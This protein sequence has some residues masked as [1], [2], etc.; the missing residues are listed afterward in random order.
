[1]IRA[2][3]RARL[4]ALYPSAEVRTFHGTGHVTAL[5]APEAFADAVTGFLARV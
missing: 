2:P 1:M 3:D 5:A 4:R